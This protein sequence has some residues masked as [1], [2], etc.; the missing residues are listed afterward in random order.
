MIWLCQ[1]GQYHVSGYATYPIAF[2]TS[3][4][5]ILYIRAYFE[6]YYTLGDFTSTDNANP[7]YLITRIQGI[8]YS[9]KVLL[10]YSR[11]NE[12]MPDGGSLLVIGI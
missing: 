11:S 7:I 3:P 1:W 12:L 2:S 10:E 6:I 5:V 8:K 9:N 4:Y